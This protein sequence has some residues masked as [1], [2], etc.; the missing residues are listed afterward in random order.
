MFKKV[1]YYGQVLIFLGIALG[2]VAVAY[3]I[4]PNLSETRAEI[5]RLV[6][7][8]GESSPGDYRWDPAAGEFDVDR[9]HQAVAADILDDLDI[10]EGQSLLPSHPDGFQEGFLGG[11]TGRQGQD[12]RLT[13]RCCGGE[14][15]LARG[16][17]RP[18]RHGAS[19]LPCAR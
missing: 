7:P 12:A 14:L 8:G 19:D 1:P 17:V 6:R 5:A 10:L 2:I 11:K 4:Y 3:W 15:L 9:R 13:S 18:R 16:Q